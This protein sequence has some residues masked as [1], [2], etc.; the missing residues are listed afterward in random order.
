MPADKKIMCPD[1]DGAVDGLDRRGFLLA[2]AATAGALGLWSVPRGDAAPTPKSA[3]E[4]LVKTLFDKLSAKQKQVVCFDWDHV[5]KQRGLLRTHVS[6]NWNITEPHVASDFYTKEQQAIVRDIFKS[7]F[8]TDWHQRLFK[9]L[10]DDSGG[11]WGEGQSIA[12][13]GKPGEGKFEFVMTGRHMTMRAD[14]NTE[15][16]VAMGGP[17]FHGHAASGFHEK[18]G[19]PG[20]VFWHQALAANKVYQMLGGKQQKQALVTGRRPREWQVPL[21]GT[22][23][24]FPGIP[25]AELSKDQREG[26]QK[27]LLLLIEPYRKED[28]DEVLACLKAQGGLEACALAFYQDG[29]LG[30]DTQ[31]DNWRIEGP[32]FVWYFRGEPHVHIWINVA[33]DA[34]VKL[35]SRNL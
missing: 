32:S 29:D 15:K 11:D 3:T 25:V 14:G 10:K 31:W 13:F 20:N 35:N 24:K 18:V 7:V 26:L 21:Q 30:N 34:S 22:K 12:L 19:H 27:V 5:H 16:H 4:T 8:S 28:Q 33:D 6:N 23:G 17:I 1:C 9:Q 2:S